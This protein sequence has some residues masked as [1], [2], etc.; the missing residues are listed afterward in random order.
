M[1]EIVAAVA[2]IL[3]SVGGLATALTGALSSDWPVMWTGIGCA[4]V[5][6]ISAAMCNL[7]RESGRAK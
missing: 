2:L 4:S 3:L 1:K 5:A 7:F 6:A